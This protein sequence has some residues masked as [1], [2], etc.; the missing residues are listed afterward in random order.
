VAT[1]A[2]QWPAWWAS[3]TSA[4]MAPSAAT[5]APARS[6]SA[7]RERQAVSTRWAAFSTP[8]GVGRYT[9]TNGPSAFATGARSSA[10][11]EGRR[12]P[13]NSMSASFP[14]PRGD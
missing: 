10:R 8:P 14:E 4:S 5:G 7:R 13:V 6:R 1:A 11:T 3:G 9:V 2:R 12:V